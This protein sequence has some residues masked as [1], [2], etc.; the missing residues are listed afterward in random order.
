MQCKVSGSGERLAGQDCLKLGPGFQSL[1]VEAHQNWNLL[2]QSKCPK[3]WPI[4]IAKKRLDSQ[5]LAALGAAC[6]DD[7]ATAAGLHANQKAM[8]T[9][10]ADFGRLV[11]AFHFESLLVSVL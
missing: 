8:G 11:C 2:R 4:R 9:G 1:H 7:S 6:V 3:K 5:A 10:A